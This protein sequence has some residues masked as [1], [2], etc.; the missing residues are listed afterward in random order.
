MKDKT[1]ILISEIE[2]FDLLS[3]PLRKNAAKAEGS[4]E[5]DQKQKGKGKTAAPKAKSK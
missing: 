1:D 3:L 4:K 5:G 2:A